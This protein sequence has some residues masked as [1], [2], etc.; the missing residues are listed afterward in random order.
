MRR[1]R[2]KVIS[3][4]RGTMPMPTAAN[5]YWAM[6]IVYDQLVSGKPFRVL[7]VVDKW[8]RESN[9]LEA[10]FSLSGRC[11]IEAFEQLG[12]AHPLPRAITV[13]N[14]TES[15]RNVVYE[16]TYNHAIQLDFIRPLPC[17]QRYASSLRRKIGRHAEATN[18]FSRLSGSPLELRERMGA[19]APRNRWRHS[20][21]RRR[22]RAGSVRGGLG[23]TPVRIRRRTVRYRLPRG[24]C[25][26]APR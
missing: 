13:D 2:R 4:L 20:R 11:V 18:R 12:T 26:T 19:H 25:L 24:S 14:G 3:L 9:L 6:D 16:W 22:C 23:A 21:G 1:R 7:T 5:Q 17:I 8:S 15:T 10:D